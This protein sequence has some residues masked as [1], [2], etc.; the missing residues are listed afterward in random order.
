MNLTTLKS[1]YELSLLNLYNAG[2]TSLHYGLVLVLA[3]ILAGC[4]EPAPETRLIFPPPAGFYEGD[5]IT[6]RGQVRF[7]AADRVA[8]TVEGEGINEQATLIDEANTWSIDLVLGSATLLDL[9]IKSS[10]LNSSADL[11]LPFTIDRNA[12]SVSISSLA[13]G[14]SG[15]EGITGSGNLFAADVRLGAVVKI[16][17]STG[18]REILSAPA[19][20]Q[21]PAFVLPAQLEIQNGVI[22]VLD[23]EVGIL[24]VDPV[25][26]DRRLVSG[27]SVGLGVSFDNPRAMLIQG[28]DIIVA[29]TGID[30]LIR[31]DATTGDRTQIF[32]A[33]FEGDPIIL[34]PLDMIGMPDGKILIADDGWRAVFLID[35]ASD[36][37]GVVSN[38]EVGEGLNLRVPRAISLDSVGQLLVLDSGHDAVIRVDLLTGDRERINREATLD[39]SAFDIPVDMAVVDDTVFFVDNG[40]SAIF[41]MPAEGGELTLVSDVRQ[42]AGPGLAAP[43]D[44]VIFNEALFVTDSAT[45][46][47]VLI[48]PVTGNRSNVAQSNAAVPF[49]N[50]DYMHVSGQEILFSYSLFDTPGIVTFTPATNVTETIASVSVG[51]GP[52]L[53][54]PTEPITRHQTGE[55]LVFD[56]F[57]QNLVSIDRN[58]HVR[59]VMY[60]D[61]GDPLVPF[62]NV[63]S[64]A[65]D[66]SGGIWYLVDSVSSR[67]LSLDIDSGLRALLL[68]ANNSRELVEV[69]FDGD[70]LLMLDQRD[71]SLVALSLSDGSL[72]II[73]GDKTGRGPKFERPTQMT[74]NRLDEL[75]Y[76]VDA[77]TDSLFVVD[78]TTGDRVIISH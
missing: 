55:L 19:R 48:D 56:A 59:T 6:L 50:P 9:L 46:G 1:H 60:D 31:V 44:V 64:T 12:F 68:A 20:G 26:G 76:V 29:D 15:A 75:A 57:E 78:L 70:R 63:T 5:A 23:R 14:A 62:S 67:V 41:S 18:V 42:G 11:E 2:M 33:F 69:E 40:A 32:Q 28:N 35:L 3:V 16:S 61:S 10:N 74:L 49:P 22:T 36:E 30:A 66:D 13:S 8:L 47:L 53:I 25:S 39:G 71:A 73:S 54:L 58:S 52:F 24:R 65:A 7:N 72:T 38:A 17:S 51:S 43:F 34:S 21:G 4:N 37:Y 77:G 45:N 27:G